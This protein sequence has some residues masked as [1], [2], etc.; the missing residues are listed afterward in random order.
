MS[1]HSETKILPHT[2]DQ[3]FDLV[4]DVERYPEFLPWCV[5]ARVR[6]RDE[7]LLVADLIIGFKGF[8]QSFT[9]RVTLDR[10][11]MKIDVMYQDG[12]FK[13]LKNNW[14]FEKQKAN[15]CLLDFYVEFEFK[16]HLMQG[17][18]ETL[19]SEAV[20]RMVAAFE[21]RADELYG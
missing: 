4:A 13:Y 11:T 3:M 16:S 14:K 21:R 15:H 8:R 18:I 1:T 12:P 9:S 5:G 2:P 20:R 7:R 6:S 17:L 19:F 10:A